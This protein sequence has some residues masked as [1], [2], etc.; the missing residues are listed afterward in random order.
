M[1]MLILTIITG[2]GAAVT[3]APG[4]KSEAACQ[5][6]AATWSAQMKRDGYV[7]YYAVCAKQD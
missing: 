1:W 7:A 5:A 4:F 3:G 6:A 2:H